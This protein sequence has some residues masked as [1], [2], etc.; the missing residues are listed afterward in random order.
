MKVA[1]V[2]SG[3]WPGRYL[4]HLGVT[5]RAPR[6]PRALT[7]RVRHP[8]NSK[9]RFEFQPRQTHVKHE[10]ELQPLQTQLKDEFDFIGKHDA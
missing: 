5:K 6:D 3:Q 9:R 4:D 1:C 8:S 10:F 2:A 7:G